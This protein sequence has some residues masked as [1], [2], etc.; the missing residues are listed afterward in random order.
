[1]PE[2]SSMSGTTPERMPLAMIGMSEFFGLAMN[3]G[4]S[5]CNR[6]V[7]HHFGIFAPESTEVGWKLVF[8]PNE[9]KLALLREVTDQTVHR[10]EVTMLLRQ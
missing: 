1:M 10:G 3:D 7:R 6:V 4:Q 2:K 9:E 8:V 5:G